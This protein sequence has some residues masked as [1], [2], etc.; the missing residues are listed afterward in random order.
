MA[1]GRAIESY[2]LAYCYFRRAKY[3]T[4]PEQ[5]TKLGLYWLDAAAKEGSKAAMYDLYERLDDPEAAMVWLKRAANDGSF[6]A[7]RQ[8]YRVTC[9]DDPQTAAA[10]LHK[11]ADAGD[12]GSKVALD[13]LERGEP[14]RFD[15]EQP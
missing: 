5:D 2:A 14:V 15:I 1:D 7:M 8:M 4:T 9:A 12:F 13:C 10:W 3:G 11:A 6:R